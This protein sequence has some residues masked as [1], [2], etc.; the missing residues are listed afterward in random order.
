MRPSTPMM[1]KKAKKA[2]LC[3]FVAVNPMKPCVVVAVNP[4]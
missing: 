2:I 4:K 3:P 1:E